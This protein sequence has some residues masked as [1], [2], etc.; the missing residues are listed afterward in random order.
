MTLVK[1]PTG[2][3]L[4]LGISISTGEAVVGNFGSKNRME[5][6]AIG[7]TV[8]LAARI[9]KL[10]E[11]NEIIVDET[12][13]NQMPLDSFKFSMMPNVEIKGAATQNLYKLHA[14]L[15]EEGD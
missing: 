15:K 5:Y 9:E 7:E 4:G 11:S 3:S 1:L 8:N 6:T 13:F 2:C 14:I 12:T 10:A